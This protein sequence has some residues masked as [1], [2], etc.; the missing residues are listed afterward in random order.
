VQASLELLISKLSVLAGHAVSIDEGW[1][2]LALQGVYFTELGETLLAC[3]EI[4]A[5]LNTP[6]LTID[7]DDDSV[8][9][10]E[11]RARIAAGDLPKQWRIVYAKDHALN[12][13]VTVGKPKITFFCVNA[14]FLAWANRIDP[15]DASS[16][17][18]SETQATIIYVNGLRLAFGGA[19]LA[20]CPPTGAGVPDEWPTSSNLP[21]GEAIR[22]QIHIL[23]TTALTVTPRCF[24]LTWGD[25]DCTIAA[26]FRMASAR[27]MAAALANTI[28]QNTITLYG[29][30]HREFNIICPGDT[31]PN[32]DSVSILAGALAW[33]YAER[34]ETRLKLL[35]DRFSLDIPEEGS[36]LSGV[37][38]CVRD[39]LRQARE[40]YEFVILDRRDAYAKE[41]R[42]FLGDLKA[43]A[44]SY[45]ENARSVLTS[46]LR[47]VLAILALVG[48]TFAIQP[49]SKSIDFESPTVIWFFHS[50]GMF[51]LISL[52][53]QLVVHIRD[54]RLT[55]RETWFW[56]DKT[57]EYM[58]KSTAK[59]YLS[60]FI[61]DRRR[62]FYGQLVMLGAMYLLASAICFALPTCVIFISHL[63]D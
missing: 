30:K 52:I 17:P 32:A 23:G 5:S 6:P 47:D 45:A 38:S 33:A 50:A 24:E 8:E 51:L 58:S 22:Q 21:S 25:I 48:V 46:L 59:E 63:S 19:L 10:D 16:F 31:T 49:A 53:L 39:A 7:W 60:K 35:A 57:R 20:F 2:R 26:P 55:E 42:N 54:V 12:A 15:F 28:S 1:D 62:L 9:A 27:I 14:K 3:Q 13:N 29:V 4:L 43:Q 36:F 61:D 44:R 34:T 40:Q 41:V 56:V 18:F 11:I 37:L